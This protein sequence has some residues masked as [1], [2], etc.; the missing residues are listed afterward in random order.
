MKYDLKDVPRKSIKGISDFFSE[1]PLEKEDEVDRD[2]PD[3][4][5]FHIFTLKW[6]MYFDGAENDMG[7]EL[8]L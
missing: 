6:R 8:C 5:L 7:L 1:L 4:T 2:L 3:D